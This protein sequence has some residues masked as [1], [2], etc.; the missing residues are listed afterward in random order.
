MLD[1]RIGSFSFLLELILVGRSPLLAEISNSQ[2]LFNL[3]PHSDPPHTDRRKR[4]AWE[5]TVTHH[6]DTC[7][8]ANTLLINPGAV[9]RAAEPTVATMDTETNKVNHMLLSQ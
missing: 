3:H 8:I 7:Q 5:N 4:L 2:L 6:P 9:H 1:I